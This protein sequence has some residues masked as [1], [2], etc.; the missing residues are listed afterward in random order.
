M[1]IHALSILLQLEQIKI[2]SNVQIKFYSAYLEPSP[3]ANL[4]L[5][6][7]SYKNALITWNIE[8][9][10]RCI[11]YYNLTIIGPLQEEEIIIQREVTIKKSKLYNT[12]RT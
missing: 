11:A 5:T 6:N 1:L 3:I 4:N 12:R 8:R 7:P 9:N 2:E 10:Y